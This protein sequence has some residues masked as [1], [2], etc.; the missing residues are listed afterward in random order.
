MGKIKNTMTKALVNFGKLASVETEK[1][2]IWIFPNEDNSRLIYKKTISGV[3]EKNEDGT[4]KKI[5][6]TKDILGKKF[7]LLQTNLIVAHYVTD[8]FNKVSKKETLE[9]EKLSIM[10]GC[11]DSEAEVLKIGLFE[12]LKFVRALSLDEVAPDI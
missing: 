3:F 7:D 1:V 5:D 6:F 10:I 2:A 11:K 8:F 4:I 12:N 9:L